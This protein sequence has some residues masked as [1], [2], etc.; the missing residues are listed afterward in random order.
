MV[1]QNF[2]REQ[3]RQLN[4]LSQEL[5]RVGSEHLS[6]CSRNRSS[7]SL[8]TSPPTASGRNDCGG[9][10]KEPAA[11]NQQNAMGAETNGKHNSSDA[12]GGHCCN[13]ERRSSMCRKSSSFSAAHRI[14]SGGNGR[15]GLGGIGSLQSQN[16]A[17][18]GA[19]GAGDRGKGDGSGSGRKGVTSSFSAVNSAMTRNSDGSDFGNR[20]KGSGDSAN[21]NG[22][23]EGD[24][25]SSRSGN[26][27]NGNGR[28]CGHRDRES[29]DSGSG[30]GD[31]EGDQ[32]GRR[33]RGDSDGREDA[34]KG[35]LAFL[36]FVGGSPELMPEDSGNQQGDQRCFLLPY[37]ALYS[38]SVVQ[39][40]LYIL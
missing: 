14:S 16:R 38:E 39:E 13:S 22:D 19:R 31:G 4:K 28:A 8:Q 2:P 7:S 9:D 1:K 18:D 29:G 15:K 10:H 17:S 20:S 30:N 25:S 36:N 21:G 5:K 27:G 26:S 23:G 3:Q 40:H 12:G 6:M 35:D 32:S 24:A 37:A 34:E 33:S 11:G